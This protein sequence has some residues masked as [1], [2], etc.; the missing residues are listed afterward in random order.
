MKLTV[1]YKSKINTLI[2]ILNCG[3][4]EFQYHKLEA[5]RITSETFGNKRVLFNPIY[6][7]NICLG[8]CPYCGYKVSNKGLKR[9]ELKPSESVAEANFLKERNVNNILVLAGDY[10]HDKYLE[11]LTQN[12]S[13]IKK[14]VNPNWLGIEVATLE[15][16]E[17]KTLLNTGA[18]SVTIFQE[19]YNRERYNKLHTITEYKGDFDF[20]YNAQ[21]RAIKAGF[22]EVGFGVLYGVGFWK[23]D[24]VA[25]VEQAIILK[26]KYPDIKLRFSFPRLQESINQ[27]ENSRTETVSDFELEKI[28]VG[29]RLLF[30]ESNL[31]LTG[32][33]N[34]SFLINQLTIVNICGYDGSTEVG[35]YLN[36]KNGLSQF[37]LDKSES[38]DKFINLMKLKG[39]D[40]FI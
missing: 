40:T 4:E 30:P 31:V 37:K 33:E 26:E 3:K 8:D 2:D 12:V 18:E 38:F 29:V 1:N 15:I 25:M 21:E 23:E 9:K 39:Y 28:I 35:G 6:V 11:M 27:I 17:Y 13:A 24:T 32:R 20:R 5:E 7:S 10:R 19:T 22:K 14:E 34:Y 16:E 36:T